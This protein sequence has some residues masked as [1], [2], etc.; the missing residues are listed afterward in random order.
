M[1]L[2]LPWLDANA[3]ETE[4]IIDQVA[5]S[6]R[7]GNAEN[8]SVHFGQTLDITLA[9]TEGNYSK[10]QA[11]LIIKDFFTQHPPASFEVKHQGSSDN[12]SVYMI[13]TY[14]SGKSSYRV[15][16][17]LKNISSSLTL[18]QIQFEPE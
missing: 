9:A 15:Y 10:S 16:L 6:I 14:L 1:I 4:E 12:G 18:Q 17:L 7:Q 2:F 5:L 13:G 8:L 3:Q 11:T